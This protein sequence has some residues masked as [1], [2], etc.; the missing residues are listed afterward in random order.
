MLKF[1]SGTA[2]RLNELQARLRDYPA[3]TLERVNRAYQFAAAAHHGQAR[4]S[5][6]AYIAHPIEVALILVDMRMDDGTLCAALLH[7]VV[8]DTPI[9]LDE[10]RRRFGPDVAHMVD[11]VSKVSRLEVDSKLRAEAASFQ[12]MYLAMANDIRVILIKLADRLHNMRTL[13]SLSHKKQQTIAR[14]TLDIYAPIA[15]RLGMR[16]ICQQMEDLSFQTLYPKRYAA[17]DRR[18]KAMRHGRRESVVQEMCQR[19]DEA[20]RQAEIKAEVVWR[21]KSPYH[22]YRKLRRKQVHSLRDIND[23]HGLRVVTGGWAACYQALGVIHQLYQP[24]PGGFRDYVAIPKA[25]GYQSLHTMVVGP[26]GEFVEVQIRSRRMHQVAEDG[27]ASHWRYET[28]AEAGAAPQRL[29]QRWLD[30]FLQH[31]SSPTDNPGEYLEHLKADLH[32]DEVYVFTPQG[33]I[34]QLPRGATV[35]DFAYS[36]H[37]D[38]GNHCLR[39]YIDH[40]PAAL[41]EKLRNG[42]TVAITSSAR[43][44]PQ[45]GWLNYAVTARA[46]DAIRHYLKQ[47]KRKQA[48]QLGSRLLRQALRRQ[49]QRGLILSAKAKQRVLEQTR[50]AD[51]PQLMAEIGF[52]ER[53]AELVAKQFVLS[54][55]AESMPNP[56]DP[57]SA[58]TIDGTEGLV[59][60]YAQCC[61][62]IP[63]DKVVGLITRG[64]GVVVHRSQ[65]RNCRILEKSPDSYCRLSW[66]SAL[67][68]RFPVE[69]KLETRNK[70]GALARV[71]HIIAGHGSNINQ[72]VMDDIL[73]K[74]SRMTLTIEVQNRDNL[75]SIVRELHAEPAVNKVMRS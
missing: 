48:M 51:W 14:Q 56:A 30:N 8:E 49:G 59:L 57:D 29:A 61:H 20:L 5:G 39:G 65:C 62:P 72:V 11:G 7:D 21:E 74:T 37:S 44:K 75:A 4:A 26:F 71:S 19:A 50:V 33:D 67:R 41:H 15:N 2:A 13:G 6:E 45:P 24:K 36:V 9:A 27:V 35:L 28:G 34:K 53:L 43:A 18:L 32:P 69:V 68:G 52:G 22:I 55:S 38:I 1:V 54:S 16:E 17:I 10:I 66:S 73:G 46:R 64:R 3:G 58:I 42:V 70:P 47:Q 40:Q 12:K 31:A 60:N 23:I 63:G 25:N